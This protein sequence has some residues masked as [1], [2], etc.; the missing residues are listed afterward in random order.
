MEG[1]LASGMTPGHGG[2]R[3]HPCPGVPGLGFFFAAAHETECPW[4]TL[5]LWATVALCICV[6]Y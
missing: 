4:L 3:A 6:Y 1:V 2:H 5:W